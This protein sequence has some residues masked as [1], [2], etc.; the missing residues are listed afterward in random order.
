MTPRSMA[1]SVS[2][3]SASARTQYDHDYRWLSD[4]CEY[5]MNIVMTSMTMTMSHLSSIIF[6]SGKR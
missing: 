4:E 1:H 5:E 3:D 2:L 6:V